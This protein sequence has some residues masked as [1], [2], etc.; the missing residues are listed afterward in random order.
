VPPP[1]TFCAR[2]A[3]PNTVK[4]CRSSLGFTGNPFLDLTSA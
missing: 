2:Q 4:A 3:S 1:N